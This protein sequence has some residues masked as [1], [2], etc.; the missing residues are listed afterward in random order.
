MIRTVQTTE[1]DGFNQ[2][3]STWTGQLSKELMGDSTGH[4]MPWVKPPRE[5]A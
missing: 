2:S 5:E 4:F 3:G 1:R